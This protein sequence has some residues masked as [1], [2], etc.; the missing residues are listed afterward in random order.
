MLVR[1][2]S[3]AGSLPHLICGVNKSTVGASLLAKKPAQA[4]HPQARQQIYQHHKPTVGASLLAKRPAQATHTQASQQIYQ[5]HKPT[6]GASLLAKRPSHPTSL[7]TDPPPSRAGSLPQ[8]TVAGHKCHEPRQSP[9]GASLLAKRPA[10]ATHNFQARRASRR[11]IAH[12]AIRRQA[13][14]SFG[15]STTNPMRICP[16]ALGPKASPASTDTP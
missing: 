5:H 6:V 14:A 9:V 10:Q 1:P 7:L 13:S 11:S 2:L 8:W 12:N 4:T 3:R 15:R 16:A